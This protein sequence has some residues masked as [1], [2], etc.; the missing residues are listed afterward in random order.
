MWVAR[1]KDGELDLYRNK[2]QRCDAIGWSH[3][4]WDSYDEHWIQLDSKLFPDLTWNDEP[5]EVELVRKN[6]N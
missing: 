4:N 3:E 6:K 1:Y 2:P 5:I